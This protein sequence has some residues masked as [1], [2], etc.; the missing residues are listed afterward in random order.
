MRV[1]T[2]LDLIRSSF[3]LAPPGSSRFAMTN[4]FAVIGRQKTDDDGVQKG[5]LHMDQQLAHMVGFPSDLDSLKILP[6]LYQDFIFPVIG[7]FHMKS[8]SDFFGRLD[9]LEPGIER[10][11]RER[12]TVDS[13]NLDTG[14]HRRISLQLRPEKPTAQFTQDYFL[15]NPI[16]S[17]EIRFSLTSVLAPRIFSISHRL[18]SM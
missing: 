14:Q 7:Q 8:F 6:V 2:T 12:R 17:M 13:S 4:R 16:P 10:E 15:K 5:F 1:G 3:S 18:D 9:D 11:F